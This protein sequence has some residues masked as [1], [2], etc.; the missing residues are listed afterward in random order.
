MA[1]KALRS[2]ER[3]AVRI[4]PATAILGGS[5]LIAAGP[6]NAGLSAGGKITDKLWNVGNEM[7]TNPGNVV[8]G[9]LLVLGGI[10]GHK[11]IAGAH[12]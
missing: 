6:I 5:A 2:V 4:I 9:T 1:N 10:V 3:F 8:G 11:V 7:K 12:L